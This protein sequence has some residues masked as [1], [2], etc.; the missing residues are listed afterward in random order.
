[1]AKILATC[2]TVGSGQSAGLVIPSLFIGSLGG[3]LIAQ[4]IGGIHPQ[5]D[6]SLVVACMTATLAGMANVPISAA[7]MLSEMAGL[8]AAVPA[9]IG[10]VVGFAVAHS[11]VIYSE[12]ADDNDVNSLNTS[13]GI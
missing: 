3:V 9:A 2:F 11:Q 13:G 7:V 6:A 8:A 10:S 5:L 4:L 1:M 12:A